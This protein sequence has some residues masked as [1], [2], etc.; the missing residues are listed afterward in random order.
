[1]GTV[2]SKGQFG[3]QVYLHVDVHRVRQLYVTIHKG[4]AAVH[5]SLEVQPC[6]AIVSRCWEDGEGSCPLAFDQPAAYEW[7]L[8]GSELTMTRVEDAVDGRSGPE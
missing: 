1:E 6:S 2:Q 5:P 7:S 8:S 4:Q 3:L